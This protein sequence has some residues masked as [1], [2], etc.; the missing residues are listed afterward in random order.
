MSQLVVE[1]VTVAIGQESILKN[2]HFT[3]ETGQLI[4]LIGHNG[5]GKSTLMKTIMGWQEK[6]EGNISVQGIDQDQEFLHYKRQIAYIP[7]EP[8]LL[9]EL[10][11]MQHFQLYGKS[12]QLS[13]EKLNQKVEELTNL[14]EIKDKLNVY[15]E[16][17]SK[18]M[19]QK[20]QTI[21]A[22]LPEVD[23][24]L[25]D[26]PFMGL[27]IHAAAALQ[28]LLLEKTQGGTSILLTSHQLDRI[29]QVADKYILLDKGEIRE[30]DEMANF[31]TITRRTSQ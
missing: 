14:F 25:I 4:A 22:L 2:I 27:D 7:E 3:V 23:L 5:A 10:T 20:V 1:N 19:R 8:F 18:G 6:Q 11:A 28:Q 16:S 24:L 12:Y 9:S 21:C 17:L 31:D 29:N 15:P 13:E 26:E 30:Y